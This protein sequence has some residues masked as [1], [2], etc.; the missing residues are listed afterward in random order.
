MNSFKWVF[1]RVWDRWIITENNNE[2]LLDNSGFWTDSV[3][4]RGEKIVERTARNYPFHENS[5][6]EGVRHRNK[7]KDGKEGGKNN[8]GKIQ[9]KGG[10]KFQQE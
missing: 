4:F 9:K 3:Q 10:G 8:K 5:E 2:T 1:S 6:K 7:P